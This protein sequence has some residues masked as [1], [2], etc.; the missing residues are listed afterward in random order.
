MVSVSN[1]NKPSKNRLAARA[2]KGK[3]A[4]QKSSAEGKLSRVEKAATK[5]GARPGLLPTSGPGA[6]LSSKK[7]RKLERKMAHAMKRKMEAEGE[8]EMKDV[9]EKQSAKSADGEPTTEEMEVDI[10]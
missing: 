3:K 5:R 8:V 2:A 10:S 1:P 9:T 4:Q 6:K 7:A